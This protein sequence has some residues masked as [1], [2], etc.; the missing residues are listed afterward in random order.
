MLSDC[1]QMVAAGDQDDL[2]TVLKETAADGASDG[3][4]AVDDVTHDR[5]NIRKSTR[6]MRTT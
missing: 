5:E 4:G 3:A 1:G 6:M 2:A